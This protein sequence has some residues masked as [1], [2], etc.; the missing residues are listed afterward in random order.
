MGYVVGG[1]CN[2]L[3][4]FNG[5]FVFCLG[6]LVNEMVLKTILIV[7]K[8]FKSTHLGNSRYTR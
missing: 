1:M 8:F 7:V 4:E 3:D 5:I 2:L 6:V